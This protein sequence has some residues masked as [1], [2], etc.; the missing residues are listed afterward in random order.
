MEYREI[1]ANV[2]IL[3]K[4]HCLLCGKK[5]DIFL[6]VNDVHISIIPCNYSPLEIISITIQY[7]LY[8]FLFLEFTRVRKRSADWAA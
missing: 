3:I 1:K 8:W 6:V 2:A 4:G 7:G 5:K